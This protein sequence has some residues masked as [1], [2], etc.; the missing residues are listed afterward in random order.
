MIKDVILNFQGVK[1]VNKLK[2]K[3]GE[4]INWYI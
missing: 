2:K 4:Q 3:I 1:G